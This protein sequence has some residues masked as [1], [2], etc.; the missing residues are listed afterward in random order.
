MTYEQGGPAIAV[1]Q[2]TKR[3]G[4]AEALREASFEVGTGTVTAL[5]GPNGAGKT[6]TIRV[7]STLLRPDTGMARVGGHDVVRAPERVQAII[8]LTGEPGHVRPPAPPAV[9]GG[10]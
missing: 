10:A 9:A 1:V 3:F 7:L 6:T 2:L 5:L 8:G 4:Q